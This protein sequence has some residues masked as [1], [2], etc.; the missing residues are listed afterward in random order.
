M[1]KGSAGA[2]QAATAGIKVKIVGGR[3]LNGKLI[4]GVV[5]VLDD[6]NLH[7]T[8]GQV[9]RVM[10]NMAEQDGVD[11]IQDVPQDPGQAGKAQVQSIVANLQGYTVRHSPES[12]DKVV[13]ADPLSAQ[14]EAGNV[15]LVKGPWN[16][17][18][19]EEV[20]YFPNGRKDRIDALVR[21]YSRALIEAQRESG[22]VGGPASIGNDRNLIPEV[23][24]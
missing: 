15:K 3:L 11:C 14:V 13:R 10:R 21:A 8:A 24:R 7:G 6:V 1:K 17:A 18:F 23:D 22:V 4:G 12:G 20:S 16:D 2:K 5:Y 9:S 19:L